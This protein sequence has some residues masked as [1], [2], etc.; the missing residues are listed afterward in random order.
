M[1]LNHV[2]FYQGDRSQLLVFAQLLTGR[3]GCGRAVEQERKR[4][5]AQP[6]AI[7]ALQTIIGGFAALF[8]ILVSSLGSVIGDVIDCINGYKIL[9][10]MAAYLPI[11]NGLF[12]GGIGICFIMVCGF[13]TAICVAL[14]SSINGLIS[15]FNGYGFATATGTYTSHN[16]GFIATTTNEN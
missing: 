4:E 2:N 16:N 3:V 9:A 10:R 7:G 12:T 11:S 6:E 13:M 1:Q 5:E 14:L 8:A 15:G